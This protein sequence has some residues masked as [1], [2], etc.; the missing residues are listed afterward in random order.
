MS[1][2]LRKLTSKG[3]IA[4]RMYWYAFF[5]KIN[6][7]R[8]DVYSGLKGKELIKEIIIF[9]SALKGTAADAFS[10]I[11][12][13]LSNNFEAYTFTPIDIII[14]SLSRRVSLWFFVF[15]ANMIVHYLYIVLLHRRIIDY[16][17]FCTIRNM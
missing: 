4:I 2:C 12:F 6:T 16:S 10:F 3:R 15:Y 9:P 7:R 14:A 5:E 1:S 8:G 11:R 13:A 17:F